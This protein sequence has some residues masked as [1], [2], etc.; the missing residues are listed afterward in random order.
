MIENKCKSINILYL[1]HTAKWS[2][3]EIALF[4][5]LSEVNKD[6]LK[7]NIFL[8][9]DGILADKMRSI[10][11]RTEILALGEK[12]I[13]LRK[14]Q[15]GNKSISNMKSLIE[16]I[17]YSLIL[18]KQMNDLKTD[19][20]H[21]NSLKSDIYGGIASKISKIPVIWHVRDHISYPYL[22]KKIVSVFKKLAKSLPSGII[23]NSESTMTCLLGNNLTKCK[24][25]V[26]YDGLTDEELNSPPR[27]PFSSWSETPKI[28]ILGR[29]VEWKGQHVFLD[30]A[31]ILQ[32]RGVI[33]KYQVIG[34][35]LFGEDA[36]EAK[37]INKAKKINSRVEFL[38]FRSDIKNVLQ[39][40]DILA[41]CSILPEPFGQVIIE[42]MAEGL[43]VIAT[44]AGGVKEI[45]THGV[46]GVLS[47]LGDETALANDLENLLA[48]P[49]YASKL[50]QNA[51]LKIRE[52][53]T[54]EKSARS[55]ESFYHEIL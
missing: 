28:G 50:G 21:C 12:N 24:S 20:V 42:G 11:I 23:A 29:I 39:N 37:I 18:S 8:A 14:D 47:S 40:L 38:G 2:G 10:G 4:R 55:I 26:I 41:H 7:T 25:R 33:A 54:A 3:G 53:F 52:K 5:S 46:D 27:K 35:S 22:P 16:Y 1:N 30:A 43:P 31:E 45:I 36:Y 6:I 44:N 32:K 19:L 49:E 9:E 15:L 34:A 17:R 13:E 48:H 51:Y